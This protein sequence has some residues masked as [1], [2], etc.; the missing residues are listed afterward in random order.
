MDAK[1]TPG[2]WEIS[3]G[4]LDI[5]SNAGGMKFIARINQPAETNALT[6]TDQASLANA[7]LIAAA[8]ELFEALFALLSAIETTQS[9]PGPKGQELRGMAHAA[10]AKA[11]GQ[12]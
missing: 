9:I 3:G 8:P 6:P 7:H 5:R 12:S 1:F 10:L 11:K 4:N 2:P